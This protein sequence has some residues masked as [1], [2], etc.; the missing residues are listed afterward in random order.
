MIYKSS[1]V[2]DKFEDH[3]FETAAKLFIEYEIYEKAY[4]F[5]EVE[6]ELHRELVAVVETN[7]FEVDVVVEKEAVYQNVKK[8][9]YQYH[10]RDFALGSLCLYSL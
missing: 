7:P 2:A 1:W 8:A 3:D 10:Y 9:V 4:T 5:A 6:E